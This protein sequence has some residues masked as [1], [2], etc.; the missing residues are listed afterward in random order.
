MKRPLY[1]SPLRSLRTA[2]LLSV[3][4]AVLGSVNSIPNGFTFDDRPIVQLNEGI[5][6]PDALLTSLLEPYWPNEYG[7]ALGLWRPVTTALFGVVWMASDG[8]PAAFHTVLV[9]LHALTT[10]LVVL[11]LAR[12]VPVGVAFLGGLLFA[13][14]PVHT[15]SVANVV[16]TAEVLS[17][18]FYLGACLIFLRATE[19]EP[20][21]GVRSSLAIAGLF[22]LAFLTKESAVTLPGIL[23]LLDGARRRSRT[24]GDIPKML[25]G[26]GLMYGLIILGGAGILAARG[27]IL[28]SVASPEPPL[29]MELLAGDVPRIWTVAQAWPHYFRLLFFPLELSADYSPGVIPITYGWNATNVLGAILVMAALIGAFFTWRSGPMTRNE[30]SARAAGFGVM[31]FVI[32]ISPISNVIFLSGVILAERT[33]YLPSVGFVVGAAW[34]L[35][36]FIRE[37]RM[38]GIAAS[39]AVVVAMTARTVTRTPVWVD[40]L[41]LFASIVRTHPES[42]RAQWL[43]ADASQIV[44]NQD[45]AI[46]AYAIAIGIL[47]GSY[48]LLVDAG[49]TLMTAGRPRAAEVVLT[50]AWRDR[51]DQGVAQQVLS[52]LYYN[53]GRYEEAEEVARE[54][55]QFF[56]GTDPASSHLLAQSLAR[57]G[58]WEESAEARIRTIELANQRQWQQWFGLGEAYINSGDT[59]RARVALDS[60][61]VRIAEDE[62]GLQ[63]VDSVRASLDSRQ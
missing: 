60:A 44:G 51:S 45:Q 50:R 52:A 16:G 17:A 36:E 58:R 43:I 40:N 61:R 33:L 25:R 35:T 57:L 19:D 31:W 29:G 4:L 56:E 1:E 38:V 59:V 24:V 62:A 49:R 30:T 55:V 53:S 6:S 34:L 3:A 12:L 28:G 2:V 9:L 22:V 18:V 11:V 15:E 8:N 32:T 13:V 41:T 21:V 39:A 7:S 27:Q 5:H 48:P 46:R 54:A 63:L 37:R 42:G 10:A 14:H 23:F 20:F 26:Q 47:N